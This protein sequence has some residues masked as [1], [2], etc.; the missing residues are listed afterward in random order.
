M[1]PQLFY[2]TLGVEPD[3]TAA[4]L[5]RA[6]R[7]LVF[8]THPDKGGDP[9][10]F[11][12]LEAAWEVLRDSTKRRVYDRGDIQPP[13]DH[14]LLQRMMTKHFENAGGLDPDWDGLTAMMAHLDDANV[15]SIAEF[16]QHEVP[17]ELDPTN[18][19]RRWQVSKGKE[20]SKPPTEGFIPSWLPSMILSFLPAFRPSLPLSLA[21]QEAIP[22]P[23]F[24]PSFL[25]L[26]SSRKGGQEEGAG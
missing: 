10:Q 23:S 20:E 21:L 15:T 16:I 24:L 4:E 14:A 1:D 6:Y 25:H 18:H 13:S 19:F 11:K 22:S 9:D 5:K 8:K 17:N 7:R 3:A 26:P 2:S 12:R